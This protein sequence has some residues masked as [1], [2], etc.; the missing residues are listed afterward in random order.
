MGTQSNGAVE[1]AGKT[2]REMI[3]VY[4]CRLKDQ[5]GKL[6]DD[7]VIYQWVTRW[8]AMAYNRFQQGCDGRT[9]SQHQTGR[10][11]RSEATPFGE[12]LLYR[13]SQPQG[14]HKEL[15][16][17]EWREGIWLG[18]MRSSQEV[19]I[20]TPEE[21]GVGLVRK[22]INRLAEMGRRSNQVHDGDT[23]ETS[24]RVSRN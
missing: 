24:S 16:E 2:I 1:E 7:A 6:D 18:H 23:E 8:A 20:G 9:A 5:V 3:K 21:G 4:R 22:A 19:L 12:N 10:I 15:M 13:E 11:C 14:E 17:I